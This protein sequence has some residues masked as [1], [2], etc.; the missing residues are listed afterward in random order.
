MRSDIIACRVVEDKS[1][2]RGQY[3]HQ[4]ET[5]LEHLPG[6]QMYVQ[7]KSVGFA[8]CR[9]GVSANQRKRN[10][11][12]NHNTLC[13]QSSVKSSP[14]RPQHWACHHHLSKHY[15]LGRFTLKRSYH[16]TAPLV[17]LLSESSTPDG[18]WQV[19]SNMPPPHGMW[20]S[21]A[22][23][24]GDGEKCSEAYVEWSGTEGFV[25]LACALV[26]GSFAKVRE[27]GGVPRF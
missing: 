18:C 19:V 3:D 17:P 7:R 2:Q 26:A 22:E 4:G 25:V 10:K 8:H 21:L 20:R 24:G 27:N 16:P 15:V 1:C 9:N 23:H 12:H 6:F 11:I 5:L 14:T 13:V